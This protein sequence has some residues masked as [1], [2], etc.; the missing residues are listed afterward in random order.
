MTAGEGYP[1]KLFIY[2]AAWFIIWAV[3]FEFIVPVNKFLPAPSVLIRAFGSLWT[4][5]RLGINLLSSVS[6]LYVSLALS[7]FLVSYLRELFFR[8][9]GLL[10]NILLSLEWF[11]EFVPGIIIGILLVFWF[12]GSDYTEFLFL[13][14][15][16]FA[17]L[18]ISLFKLRDQINKGYREAAVSLGIKG[19]ELSKVEFNSVLPVLAGSLDRLHYYAWTMLIIFEFINRSYGLG[20]VLRNALEYKDLSAFTASLVVTGVIIYAGNRLL[21]LLLEKYVHWN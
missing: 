13:F 9:R 6:V 10:F 18:G 7:F 14:C 12:P 1:K 2:I 8:G 11:A 15:L 4:D 20:A 3:V 19:R 16:C 17:S 5:Y 21:D